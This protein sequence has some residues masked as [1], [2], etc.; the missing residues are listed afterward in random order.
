[1]AAASGSAAAGCNPPW[2]YCSCT[3]ASGDASSPG[4]TRRRRSTRTTAS[5]RSREGSAPPGTRCA[6]RRR[7]RTA[8]RRSTCHGRCSRYGARSRAFTPAPCRRGGPSTHCTR[9]A[10][11]GG[12]GPARAKAGSSAAKSSSLDGRPPPS[13]AGCAGSRARAGPRGRAVVQQRRSRPLPARSTRCRAMRAG[14][15]AG[16]LK[17]AGGRQREEHGRPQRR[18]HRPGAGRPPSRTR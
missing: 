2:S 8:G 12:L 17:P 14:R 15:S 18:G 1:M 9:S 7:R 4:A 11:A 16:G 3:R 10:I 13:P 5:L 6:R